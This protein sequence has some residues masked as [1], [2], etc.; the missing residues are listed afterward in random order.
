MLLRALVK[1]E[2]ARKSWGN[3]RAS[4]VKGM[5]MLQTLVEL[6]LMQVSVEP[7][8]HIH[9]VV[10]GV[11]LEVLRER[12]FSCALR[13]SVCV[14]S[15]FSIDFEL[16]H[17]VVYSLLLPSSEEPD[18]QVST[19]YGHSFLYADSSCFLHAYSIVN[20]RPS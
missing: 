13:L 14:R 12:H 10:S 19:E 16:F 8:H 18:L 6:K 17:F 7:G 20:A 15:S 3:D 4:L 9:R 2:T 1:A 11:S 5:T